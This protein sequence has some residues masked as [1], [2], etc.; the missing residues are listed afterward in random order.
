MT[1]FGIIFNV[2]SFLILTVPPL[3]MLLTRRRGP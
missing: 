3:S 1:T 2:L